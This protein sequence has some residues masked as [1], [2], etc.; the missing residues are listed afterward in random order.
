MNQEQPT[1]D[2]SEIVW[3]PQQVPS[4]ANYACIE[5]GEW[6]ASGGLRCEDCEYDNELEA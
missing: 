3:L 5:C 4:F 2:T 6:S 1:T